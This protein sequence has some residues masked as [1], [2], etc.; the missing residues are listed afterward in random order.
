MD[1]KKMMKQAQ[2]MQR[3][4]AAAQQEIAAMTNPNMEQGKLA[5]VIRGA[6]VFI[7]VSAPGVL[8][9]DMIRTMNRDAIIFACA[10]PTPEI[11]P[12]SSAP[13]AAIIPIRSIM[14]SHS[15]QYSAARSTRERRTSTAK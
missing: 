6:D 1:M 5:D 4:A 11:M 14:S 8:T 7:G 15:R 12:P 10:N 9:Q 2:K 3:D 13:G